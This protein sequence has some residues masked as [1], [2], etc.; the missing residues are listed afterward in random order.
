MRQSSKGLCCL[1]VMA[2]MGAIVAQNAWAEGDPAPGTLSPQMG[3]ADE[4]LLR[5]MFANHTMYGFYPPPY[6][7]K[8]AEYY[9]P[10]GHTS[11]VYE[12]ELMEGRCGLKPAQFAFR[13]IR[14]A[15]IRSNATT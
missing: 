7:G 13:M 11:F 6:A 15:M 9:C 3:I 1:V 5:Q 10:T 8:W 2:L 12:D 4:A 14:P